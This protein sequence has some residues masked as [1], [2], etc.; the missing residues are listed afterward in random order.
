[1]YQP[2][3]PPYMGYPPSFGPQNRSSSFG[4]PSGYPSAQ[5]P[6]L[7]APAAQNGGV[8][9]FSVQ[10]VTSREEALA[11]I[12]DPLGSGVLLPD[13]GHG[14]IYVKKF[15]ANTG[16]SDFWEFALR[17]EQTAPAPQEYTPLNTFNSAVS[18]LQAEI[19]ALKKPQKGG[20][21]DV[22]DE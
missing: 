11:V 13:L 10:P 2:A 4:A 1:M 18:Q 20:R 12:A 8:G 19:E 14:V 6:P 21:R 3:Y 17:P 5:V 15:N 7:V 9:G 16:A 22:S